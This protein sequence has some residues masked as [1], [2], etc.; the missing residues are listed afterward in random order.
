MKTLYVVATP[1]GN[2]GDLTP[3]AREVLSSVDFV[4]CEDTRVGGKLMC[5]AELKKPLLSY[6][7][8]NKNSRHALILS[9]LLSGLDAALITDAGT[10]CISDPGTEM[11]RLAHENGIKVVP[12]P[13]ACAAVTAI[14]ASGIDCRRF[15]FEGFLEKNALERSQRLIALSGESRPIVFYVAVHEYRETVGQLLSVFGN[16]RA[17]LCRELTKLNE[18]TLYTDLQTLSDTEITEKGEFVLVVEGY[19]GEGDAFWKDMDIRAH[20]AYYESLGNTRMESIKLTAL[21][22]KVPK[23]TI[24]KEFIED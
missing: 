7:E 10:P 8:H 21:D 4:L 16:R 6:Y 1:I 13:G 19:S 15:V 22:R 12:I 24:Y 3:R 9:K 23:S 14:C 5:L 18:Q 2:M 17:V 11:V 20:V